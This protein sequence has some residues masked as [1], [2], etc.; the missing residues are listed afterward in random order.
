MKKKLL[1][2]VCFCGLLLPQ[3]INAQG[4]FPFPTEHAVWT[5]TTVSGVIG[6]NDYYTIYRNFVQGDT[7]FNSKVYTKAYRQKLCTCTCSGSGPF[8]TTTQNKVLIGGVREENG[9][10]YFSTFGQ[11]PF[12]QYYRPV[13]DT[14]LFDFTLKLGDTI[15]YGD[16]QLAVTKVDS[17]MDGRKRIHLLGYVLNNIPR[18]FSWIE[19]IGFYGL[20]ETIPYISFSTYYSGFCFSDDPSNPCPL[21]PT[22]TLVAT[23]DP[24][25]LEQVSIY[26]SLA[27]EL[28]H[29]TL[30]QAFSEV[31]LQIFSATGSLVRTVRQFG[32]TAE[33]DVSSLPQGAYLFVFESTEGVPVSKWYAR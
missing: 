8:T 6:P 30:G 19:G 18:E 5:F 20:L 3:F 25:L 13:L 32:N 31:Q 2:L 22:C 11:P 29:I 24:V 4:P 28:V 15:L 7:L 26:P 27:Q 12:N 16:Y 9:K 1:V 21:P 10:V 14:L 17:T 33:I 23:T